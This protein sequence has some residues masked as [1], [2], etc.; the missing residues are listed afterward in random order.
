MSTLKGLAC[1]VVVRD[2]LDAE[3]AVMVKRQRLAELE[4]VESIYNFIMQCP[5]VSTLGCAVKGCNA[6]QFV[7]EFNVKY[8][9]CEDFIACNSCEATYCHEHANEHLKGF[10][11]DFCDNR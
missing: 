2:V 5:G 8:Y 10:Y 6:F 1:E 11:C 7:Y 3:E 9:G 4:K